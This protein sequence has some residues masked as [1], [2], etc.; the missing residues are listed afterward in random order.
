MPTYM[1]IT[2]AALVLSG[3]A[4]AGWTLLNLYWLTHEPLAL[5][6]AVVVSTGSLVIPAYTEYRAIRCNDRT[7]TILCIIGWGLLAFVSF[8][9]LIAI[10]GIAQNSMAALVALI[11]LAS[12]SFTGSHVCWLFA[13]NTR[14]PRASS[15]GGE[16]SRAPEP[17]LCAVTN[18]QST[19]P[20]R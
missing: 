9:Q 10:L 2:T 15:S 8:L 4:Y 16:P 19:F 7:A 5:A 11:T 18:G 6:I 13:C 12:L 3:V 17:G 14:P 20:A 1:K